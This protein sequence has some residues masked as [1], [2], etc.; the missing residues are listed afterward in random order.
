MKKSNF[1]KIL[2]GSIILLPILFFLISILIIY[3]KQDDIVKN[4]LNKANEN[5]TGE[6]SI[7]DQHISPFENFPYISIDLNH[8][9]LL[10]E[11]A[12]KSKPILDLEHLYIGFDLWTI[13][14]GKME[15]K[16]IELN[17]G[18]IDLIQDS[19]GT[20]NITKALATKSKSE[21]K[22]EFKIKLKKIKVVNVDINKLNE[23]NKIKVDVFM[24]KL[25][26]SFN[27]SP[28]HLAI[29]CESDF[30]INILKGRDTTFFKRK[31]LNLSSQLDYD[32]IKQILNISPSVVNMEYSDFKMSGRINI[33]NDMDLSLRFGGRK[34]N[35]DLLLAF[36][37]QGFEVLHQKFKNKGNVYFTASV[38]GKSINGYQPLVKIFFGCKDAEFVNIENGRKMD[39]LNFKM[40]Y[41][42]GE[43]R[44][45]ETMEFNLNDLSARMEG[46]NI[47][48]RIQVKNFF[49]PEVEI[50]TKT[51][52]DLE[53][54]SSFFN[55]KDI[56]GIRGNL[57]LD[58][59][60]ADIIDLKNP[61][62]SLQNLQN[63]YQASI[64]IRNLN[65]N[66]KLLK[67][68]LRDL[69]LNVKCKGL[70]A[71][72][73]KCSGKIGKSDISIKAFIDDLPA[74]IHHTDKK[75]NVALDIN[76]DLIDLSE[77]TK[78]STGTKS[79]LDEK[80]ENLAVS[81]NFIA[82]AK[83]FTE[84]K[85]LPRGEFDI[86]KFSAQFKN[87]PHALH[88]LKLHVDIN[89]NELKILNFKGA[90][91]KSDFDILCTI[92]NY[93]ILFD[94]HPNGDISSSFKI[95]SGLLQFEDIFTYNSVN[96]MPE[97]YRHEELRRFHIYG[98]AVVN[99]KE[100]INSVSAN[101]SHLDAG[102]KV[103]PL[104]VSIKNLQVNY[105][106][107]NLKID[108]IDLTA[109]KTHLNARIDY[110]LGTDSLMSKKR[111]HL[112][113]NASNLDL[114]E[115]MNYESTPHPKTMTPAEH[116]K[117]FNIYDLPFP[118]M[119]Y[120]LSISNL[121]YH[122]YHITD[123]STSLITN[124]NHH[125]KV[126]KLNMT[127]AGGKIQIKGEFDG[128]NR[129]KIFFD[130]DITLSK[131]SIDQL[132]FKF[133]NFGQE[134][135]VSDNIHGNLS[136]K[137]SGHVRVHPDMIPVL[138]ESSINLDLKLTE[139]K[140]ENYGP[141]SVLSNY[142]KD[143]NLNRIIFD[144][145]ENHFRINKGVI[146]VPSMTINSSLGFIDISGK[147]NMDFDM[148]YFVKVPVKMVTRAG[149]QRLFGKS[150]DNTGNTDEIQYKQEGKNIK[151]LPIKIK[152]KGADFKISLG[153]DKS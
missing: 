124:K 65:F 24:N 128:T 103:H 99:Y 26:A 96:Y 148:E 31:H 141:M 49:S 40:F 98:N 67:L 25:I 78:D 114:D 44:N 47:N 94:P 59:S 107:N 6:L 118:H 76:S 63:N 77:I 64:D 50:N 131:I 105:S 38:D 73:L 13:A 81:M 97:D 48:S 86:K 85:N 113:L 28:E 62:K 8:F 127:A 37:P 20:L 16:S 129:N 55:I 115:L 66:G 89:D 135:L 88:D 83:D 120:D 4:L 29:G 117:A 112:Y 151:Y 125:L 137:I 27:A 82:S 91:D 101:I 52:V 7:Q 111:N 75:V 147:Q 108:N 102:M 130:P 46:G 56:S 45:R 41:T 3:F 33:K 100:K 136:G 53:Y 90:I 74:I 106:D 23:K 138:D 30:V 22:N 123:F 61:A 116:E 39:K 57:M 122:R 36:A 19:A 51:K 35:F 104:S 12:S 69:N 79:A 68:P 140:L 54:L 58:I 80:I 10:S 17:G 133:E 143:K 150:S 34:P 92:K 126:D 149:W 42:N 119:S 142:F 9:K 110:Y 93:P 43:K 2:I 87:Y 72:I 152:G 134:Y 144:T 153:K 70:S 84:Y 14:Q 71:E 139:G 95:S 18:S 121:K 132:F 109:G 60:F 145:L 21:G 32:K 5:I 146:N 15:I 1:W 11:K